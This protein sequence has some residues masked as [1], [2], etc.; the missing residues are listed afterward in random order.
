M[1]RACIFL[2]L[3]K[4]SRPFVA[5][6][7]HPFLILAIQPLLFL[8][9]PNHMR[10]Y[11][12]RLSAS[13]A[14]RIY[15]HNRNCRE[16]FVRRGQNVAG[17]NSRRRT[18]DAAAGSATPPL[19]EFQT[20]VCSLRARA[21]ARKATGG[22]IHMSDVSKTGLTRRAVLG[23]GA[24]LAALPFAGSAFA[25]G[26]RA[27]S[28]VLDFHTYADVTKAE[29]EGQLVF[30]CHENEAGTAAIMEGFGRDSP[31]IKPGYVRAQT[32]ART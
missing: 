29:Q 21:A 6:R 28:K 19:A 13:T 32:G 26:T 5:L 20:D 2:V 22:G 11:S 27:P 10:A 23:A 8:P 3:Y 9:N 14:S 24:A 16:E 4:R 1:M 18:R 7:W 12:P 31:K 15:M 25:Q 30:Y 17:A